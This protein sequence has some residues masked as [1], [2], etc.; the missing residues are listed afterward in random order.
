MWLWITAMSKNQSKKNMQVAIVKK[1]RLW[2]GWRE[3]ENENNSGTKLCT[4]SL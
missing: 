1:M 2:K 3:T 4:V